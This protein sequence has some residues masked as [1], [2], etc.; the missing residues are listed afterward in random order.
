MSNKKTADI[1]DRLILSKPVTPCFRDVKKKYLHSLEWNG[2]EIWY[3]WIP[4]SRP[5]PSS[6]RTDV[7]Y[8]LFNHPISVNIL[9]I[10]DDFLKL[11]KHTGLSYLTVICVE[12]PGFTNC[13]SEKKDASETNWL[14][15]Y[16][17]WIEAVYRHHG[18]KISRTIVIGYS[19]GTAISVHLVANVWKNKP[20]GLILVSAFTSLRDV[21]A[22]LSPG[23]HRVI[24]EKLPSKRWIHR[25]EIPLLMIHG[26]LDDTVPPDHSAQLF[27]LAKNAPV[28]QLLYL[29]GISHGNVCTASRCARLINGMLMSSTPYQKKSF[30]QYI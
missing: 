16:P 25:V 12:F 4:P 11:V 1:Y 21:I 22:H 14:E 26:L 18:A 13:L 9:S 24:P 29:R 7:D 10:Y 19:I 6:L 27:E 23:M 5:R 20:K 17:Q 8:I 15:W 3:L 30:I 2:D 28:R